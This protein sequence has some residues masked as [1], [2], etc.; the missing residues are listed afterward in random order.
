MREPQYYGDYDKQITFTV[1]LSGTSVNQNIEA[2]YICLIRRIE[3]NANASGNWRFKLYDDDART[4]LAYDTEETDASNFVE[5]TPL[6]YVDRDNGQYMHWTIE[7][8]DGDSFTVTIDL[9]RMA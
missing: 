4:K 3:I 6:V 2:G 1:T 7:G 8:N 9:V 5:L